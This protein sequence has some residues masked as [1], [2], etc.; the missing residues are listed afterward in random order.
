MYAQTFT[1]KNQSRLVRL[2][3]P[4]LHHNLIQVYL[5]YLGLLVIYWKRILSLMNDHIERKS[6]FLSFNVSLWEIPSTGLKRFYLPMSFYNICFLIHEWVEG[7]SRKLQTIQPYY[8]FN[9]IT[10]V[11]CR[12]K[13][14]KAHF[15]WTCLIKELGHRGLVWHSSFIQLNMRHNSFLLLKSTITAI[16]QW[17]I[18]A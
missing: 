12:W 4:F 16:N 8:I 7:S 11:I 1:E 6:M 10:H 2:Q 5:I 9:L 3:Q 18:Q 17:F 14:L 13:P 15:K